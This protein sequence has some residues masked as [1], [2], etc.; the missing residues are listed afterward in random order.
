MP[1]TP[2]ADEGTLPPGARI[3]RY[4]VLDVLQK[5]GRSDEARAQLDAV[6]DVLD[7]TQGDPVDQADA[8]QF[9]AETLSLGA[10]TLD[11]RP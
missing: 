8:E 5:L 7:K 6:L 2:G 4:A 10:S 9:L 11:R 3:G 1:P